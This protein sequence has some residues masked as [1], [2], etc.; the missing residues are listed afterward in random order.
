[1]LRLPLG[2]VRVGLALVVALVAGLLVG[3]GHDVV[4]VGLHLLGA[5]TAAHPPHLVA[6]G[7]GVVEVLEDRGTQGGPRSIPA[8][9]AQFVAAIP[10][11]IAAL[12]GLRG[13]LFLE[14]EVQVLARTALAAPLRH[15]NGILAARLRAVVLEITTAHFWHHTVFALYLPAESAKRELEISNGN[16]VVFSKQIYVK[17]SF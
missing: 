6:H 2:A 5:A 8:P 17:F 9:T 10:L 4:R 3:P 16:L 15:Q 14:R 7:D 1:M 11:L 13:Q 12:E